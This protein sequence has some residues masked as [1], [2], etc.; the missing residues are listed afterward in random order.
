MSD[1]KKSSNIYFGDISQLTN[2]ILDSGLTCHMTPH[3]SDFIP[4]SLADKD[5]HI[6]VVDGKN[7]TEKQKGQVKINICDNNGYIFIAEL[8]NI[9]LAPGL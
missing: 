3:L 1:N 8:H 5:E 7:V 4:G 6:E 2:W 9:L